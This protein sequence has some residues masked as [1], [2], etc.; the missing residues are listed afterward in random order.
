MI[1]DDEYLIFIREI[2]KLFE[3]Y[4]KCSNQMFKE[5]IAE[6]LEILGRALD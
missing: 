2:G 3:E 1:N 5:M 6:D 4:N